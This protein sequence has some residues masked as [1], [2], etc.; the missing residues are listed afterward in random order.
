MNIILIVSDTFRRDHLGCYGNAGIHTP[1]L[2]RLSEQA[3]IFDRC[4]ASSF[5]T[6]P[7]RAD[8]FTGKY[9]FAFMEWGP[10][11]KEETIL[12]QLLRE[13]GYQTCAVVDTPFHLRLGSGYDRGFEDFQ[14]VRGQLPGSERDDVTRAWR[15]EEDLFAPTTMKTAEKWLEV[16]HREKFFL[17]VDTW[18]PHEPWDP[19]RYYV[20]L[21]HECM[22]E[23]ESP[24]P[25]YWDWRE[26][27]LSEEEVELAHAFYCG[28]ITMVDR[29]IGRLLERVESLG[30][31]EET[32]IIF[33]SDHGFYFGEHGLL[34]KG[35]L[36]SDYGFYA[37]P[38]RQ[39][40]DGQ[41]RSLF[42]SPETG[43][44]VPALG[45]WYPCP[46]YN[47]V[48]RVPLLVYVPHAEPARSDA[49]VTLP[50]LMPT[51]LQ[52]A[53]LEV[54]GTVQA[55]SVVPLLEGRERR[56][57]D[58]VVTT[59]PLTN[60]GMRTRVVDDIERVIRKTSPSTISAEEW[61]LIYNFAGEPVELYHTASDPQQEKNVFENN[62]ETA[63]QLHRKFVSFLE[64]LDTN[65]VLVAP[66]RSLQ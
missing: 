11:P 1:H 13:A 30:L 50:D 52:L 16:H 45:E 3:I 27:G 40:A 31:M 37:G 34:G 9:T 63:E 60:P 35:K 47:E 44:I 19:P 18:D 54:P 8:M 58:F 36:R 14:W 66:R 26:A 33:T 39:G 53:G 57:H 2:D 10:L 20:E 12:A 62:K 22:G 38:G 23:H 17:Y 7:A 21:Y 49:L 5:P 59:W 15:Y 32:A 46:I 29:G 64:D 43:R 41:Y 24:W 56:L 51:I 65:E 55:E 61:S 25:C 6:M 48:A 4:Y 28:E 42:K